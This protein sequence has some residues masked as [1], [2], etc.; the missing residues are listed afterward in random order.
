MAYDLPPHDDPG[1][2]IPI[3]PDEAS[4]C[5]FHRPGTDRRPQVMLGTDEYRVIREA[6]AALTADKG[7]YQRGGMLVRINREATS[8]IVKRSAGTP[9][10]GTLPQASLRERLTEYAWLTQYNAKGEVI[11]AHPPAWLVQ[12]IDARGEWE[13]IRVLSGVSESPVLRA[14]GTVCQE[15]GYDQ[16]TGVLYLPQ[17][18]FP[19]IGHGLEREDAWRASESLFEVV[20]DF[21]FEGDAH[22]AAWLAAL[23][24]PI[25]RYAFDG[26]SPF[27]LI[28]AN[29]R[30]AGKGLLAQTIGRVVLGHE[31]PVSA[32]SAD[33]DEMRKRITAIAMSGDRLVLLDNIVGVL[34]NPALDMA[35]TST[36][37]KDRIL[38]KS[39]EGEWPLHATWYGTGNNVQLGAD[40]ARRTIHIRLDVLEE[41]PELRTG[42]RHPD[43]TGWIRRERPRL[44]MDALAILAAYMQSGSPA[45][46]PGNG[47]YDGWSGLVRQAIVWIGLPDPCGT[48]TELMEQSD[49][50]TDAL[51]GLMAAWKTYDEWNRGIIV[52]DL[53]RELY[54]GA[55]LTPAGYAMKQAIEAFVSVPAGKSPSP[56]QVANHLRAVKR[57]VCGGMMLD[58]DSGDRRN[59]R[60]WKLV[61]PDKQVAFSVTVD[62]ASHAQSPESRQNNAEKQPES[63]ESRGLYNDSRDCD[64]ENTRESPESRPESHTQTNTAQQVT[65]VRDS[66]DSETLLPTHKR[67]EEI[68]LYGME[69]QTESPESPKDTKVDLLTSWD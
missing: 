52:A 43:L 35:L 29:V 41:R 56:R 34:G 25:A 20:C 46:L 48:Q 40:M 69:C 47:A 24:T 31:M 18:E 12:A 17:C 8:D 59:G 67:K 9:S 22:R 14:D 7:L 62:S 36:R 42:F 5:A 64:S 11:P 13:G 15:P 55:N 10:I 66:R 63:P 28:D 23:L 37:W 6:V 68:N 26:P 16:A 45:K 30:G 57:R 61:Q 44:V 4:A 65:T 58:C 53:M 54:G 2:T 49:M 27:F 51:G 60:R 32:Y 38:G 50:T 33:L 3:V 39:Q 1:E 21:I 19:R